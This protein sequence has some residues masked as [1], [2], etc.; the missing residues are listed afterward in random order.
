[1]SGANLSVAL[2][3]FP[4]YD[5]HRD[6]VAT[7]VT[8]LDV[9]DISRS[10]RTYGVG[11]YYIVTP[12]VEQR[13]L[14]EKIREHWLSGWGSTYNPKRKMALEILQVEDGL[15]ETLADIERRT[16]KKAK[17]VVTGAS[18]RDNSIGFEA[19]KQM[20]RDQPDQPYLLLLG[21]GWGLTEQFF[22][23]A[24]YVLEPISGG[25]DYNHLSVR[26]AAAI[27][28]DRLLGR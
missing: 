28:L 6:I 16:G 11:R 4:V 15:P 7:A 10:C 24:D 17:V 20:L 8:N 26:S 14:V 5:K 1:M 25:S 12:V 22:R 19:M 3:H 27:M 21:T 2:I 23:D 13:K 18:G 9:H